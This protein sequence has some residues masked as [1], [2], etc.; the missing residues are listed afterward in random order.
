MH[1]RKAYD[2]AINLYYYRARYYDPEIGRFISEDPIGFQGGINFYAYC[3]DNPINCNDPEGKTGVVG[4]TNG[5]RVIDRLAL[6][7]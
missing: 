5:V 2:Q 7:G 6:N 1:V 4:V 3:N